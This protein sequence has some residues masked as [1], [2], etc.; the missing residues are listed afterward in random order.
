MQV[1]D[2]AEEGKFEV[3]CA[4]VSRAYIGYRTTGFVAR[5][6]IVIVCFAGTCSPDA[7]ES[8]W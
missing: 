4:C 5:S 2:K 1:A 3:L 6:L 8:E 7:A